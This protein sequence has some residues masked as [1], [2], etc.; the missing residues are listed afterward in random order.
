MTGKEWVEAFIKSLSE[1]ENLARAND[2][3]IY[4]SDPRWTEFMVKGIMKESMSKKLDC[5]VACRDNSDNKNSYEYLN[6][7][8]MFFDEFAYDYRTSG[9]RETE[10]E[11]DPRVLPAAVIE[12]ENKGY[13]AESKVKDKIAHCLWKLLCIRSDLRVLICYHEDIDGLRKFLENTV[14]AGKL[15]KRLTGE[16]FVIIGDCSRDGDSWERREDI[17]NYF[18]IFELRNDQLEEF[19]E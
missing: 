12:H 3:N 15:A 8:A 11:Y 14:N 5:R 19:T 17:E 9:Y 10:T 6:I 13:G 1:L 16:L 4:S 7:D 18:K 2:K